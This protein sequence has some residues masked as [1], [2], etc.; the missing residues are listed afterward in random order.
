MD[1]LH[2]REAENETLSANIISSINSGCHATDPRMQ[3]NPKLVRHANTHG[4][5]YTNPNLHPNPHRDFY[6]YSN[7]HIHPHFHSDCNL[8][9]LAV[10]N[11]YPTPHAGLFT[12]GIESRRPSSW[13]R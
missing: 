9:S 6:T 2:I 3:L 11:H 10:S 5:Q 4:N 12:G 7:L 8:H 13:L 1:N